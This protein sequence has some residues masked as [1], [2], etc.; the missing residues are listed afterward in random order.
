MLPVS[1]PRTKNGVNGKMYFFDAVKA[2]RAEFDFPLAGHLRT[3]ILP[4]TI[5][6]PSL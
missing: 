2:S 4:D 1:K 3:G 6:V 5:E